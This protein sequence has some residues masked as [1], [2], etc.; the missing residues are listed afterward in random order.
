MEKY[1]KG[2]HGFPVKKSTE[3]G[4]LAYKSFSI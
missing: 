2:E 1:E 4:A 3:F